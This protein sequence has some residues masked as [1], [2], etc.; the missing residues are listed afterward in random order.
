M[1]YLVFST[2]VACCVLCPL[3]PV[4]AQIPPVVPTDVTG[5]RAGSTGAFTRQL[6]S[7]GSELRERAPSRA[8]LGQSVRKTTTSA[9]VYL[10][11]R[12]GKTYVLNSNNRLVESGSQ[13]RNR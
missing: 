5:I 3:T 7:S 4:T 10:D 1:R 6:D 2:A 13:L 9:R 11:S 8:Q 12:T